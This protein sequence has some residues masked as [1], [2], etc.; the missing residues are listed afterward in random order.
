MPPLVDS[1]RKKRFLLSLHAHHADMYYKEKK[2][3]A[4][5]DAHSVHP[6]AGQGLNISLK[7]VQSLADQLSEVHGS[8]LGLGDDHPLK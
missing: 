2:V 3:L 8:G 6:M 1:L 7:G 5:A 4:G